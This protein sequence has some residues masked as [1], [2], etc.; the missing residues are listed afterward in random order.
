MAKPAELKAA[1]ISSWDQHLY[2]PVE[3]LLEITQ[4]NAPS[5]TNTPAARSREAYPNFLTCSL[6][7]S[8]MEDMYRGCEMMRLNV[9]NGGAQTAAA[10][11]RI[12]SL[13]VLAGPMQ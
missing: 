4:F 3:N 12:P 2:L 9:S 13:L 1:S 8:N 5:N 7:M 11:Q 10:S 6:S